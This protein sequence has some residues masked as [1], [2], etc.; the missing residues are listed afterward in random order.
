MR[1]VGSLCPK[2]Y[3]YLL[4]RKLGNG[5]PGFL[6]LLT[7]SGFEVGNFFH[8]AVD[9]PKLFSQGCSLPPSGSSITGMEG[10]SSTVLRNNIQGSISRAW[11]I[12]TIVESTGSFSP[13]PAW[14]TA[15]GCAR[16]ILP[17]DTVKHLALSGQQEQLL[18][19]GMAFFQ[20][21]HSTG[22][23]GSCWHSWLLPPHS[24]K[25]PAPCPA[26]GRAKS[27]LKVWV[28]FNRVQ[29]G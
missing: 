7:K 14:P 12:T 26:R 18:Q 29:F 1:Y 21:S 9:F 13:F 5:F 20:F 2:S 6:Q 8:Y 25:F 4:L 3:G 23:I 19:K 27:A 17:N 28:P 22:T 10:I 15:V 11:A 16:S 24:P